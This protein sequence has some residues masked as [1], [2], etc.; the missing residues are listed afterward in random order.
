M[1]CDLDI[2]KGETNGSEDDIS[3]HALIRGIWLLMSSFYI[4]T[5]KRHPLSSC[6]RQIQ[7]QSF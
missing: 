6:Y 7:R 3:Q 4:M 2:A 1:H 5:N